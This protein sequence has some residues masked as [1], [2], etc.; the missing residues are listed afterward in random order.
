MKIE[1][2]TSTYDLIQDKEGKFVLTKTSIKPEK[3]SSVVAGHSFHGDVV[4]ITKNGLLIGDANISQMI[5]RGAF[6]FTLR[7]SPIQL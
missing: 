1:T 6:T 5:E 3:T 4:V 2:Q 7:T